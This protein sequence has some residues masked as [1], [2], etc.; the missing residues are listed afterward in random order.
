MSR[1]T[2]AK[3][4]RG[5]RALEQFEDRRL[6]AGDAGNVFAQFDGRATDAAPSGEIRFVVTASDFQLR[7]GKTLLGF[8]VQAAEGSALDP[9]APVISRISARDRS[10]G[11]FPP[12]CGDGE[13]SLTIVELGRGRF[14]ATVG[15]ESNST[16]AWQTDVFLV[17]DVNGDRQVN[18]LD[19][20]R[21]GQLALPNLPWLPGILGH[22]VL[23]D[24]GPGRNRLNP[25]DV[26]GDGWVNGGDL[27][28]LSQIL[29]NT[30][31]GEVGRFGGL[32][33]L[34]YPDVNGDGVL[35]N[36]DGM[37]LA[38]HLRSSARLPG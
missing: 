28:R 12:R 24:A 9:A 29:R 33:P 11:A 19:I 20:V 30:G 15:G 23:F 26:T 5:A 14:T 8:H 7:G 34:A 10:T 18:Y 13:S 1:K 36:L 35:S 25:L 17:G 38:G 22:G 37:T 16:G 4:R 32:F 21:I 31:G 2:K 3:I 27:T 6:L